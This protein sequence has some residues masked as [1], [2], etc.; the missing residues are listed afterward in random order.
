MNVELAVFSCCFVAGGLLF[1]QARL[2]ARRPALV[3][4][5]DRG[6]GTRRSRTHIS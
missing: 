1:T 5:L 3:T 2:L 4:R 6:T